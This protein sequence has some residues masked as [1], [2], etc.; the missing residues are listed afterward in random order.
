MIEQSLPAWNLS[1]HILATSQGPLQ[2][3]LDV[4]QRVLL[5]EIVYE[6]AICCW[7]TAYAS[8][9]LALADI[10]LLDPSATHRH[11]TF[12]WANIGFYTSMLSAE[13]VIPVDINSP[14]IRPD[15]DERYRPL[16]PSIVRDPGGYTI[17]C[18]S[19]NFD[20]LYGREYYVID[21]DNYVRV[22]NFLIKTDVNFKQTS[23]H[24]LTETLNRTRLNDHGLEDVRIARV[25]DD[26]WFTAFT[27][28]LSDSHNSLTVV[29][30]IATP[31]PSD[32]NVS[33]DH[34]VLMEVQDYENVMEKNW[35]PFADDASNQLL[36]AYSV[37]PNMVVIKPDVQ[38][39]GNTT[40]SFQ[41]SH[42]DL[43]RF[44][45]S[46]GPIAFQYGGI[47]GHL[48]VVHEVVYAE[49]GT[50]GQTSRT[51][52]HRFVFVDDTWTVTHL[53]RMF[54]FEVQGVEFATGMVESHTAGLVL[55]SVGIQDREAKIFEVKRE[56][57]SS[58]LFE[59]TIIHEQPYEVEEY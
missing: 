4:N 9:G 33:V 57:I 58:M 8:Y 11:F 17:M 40:E 2:V 18:K 24:E 43:S 1:I 44:R 7:Y 35:L 39:G 36:I 21:E 29:G 27:R 34:M 20:Q 50:R 6:A 42:L 54:T 3:D 19:V 5:E 51:Y 38:T 22:R 55:V 53:S 31:S 59:P 45:G 41:P 49:Y 56:T 32:A 25:G 13:R 15:K 28:S 30:H 46:A 16:N 10:I 12:L 26:L 47:N 52:Y 48:F 14:L 37:G 23:Q